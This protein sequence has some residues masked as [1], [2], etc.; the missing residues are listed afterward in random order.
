MQRLRQSRVLGAPRIEVGPYGYEHAQ[1]ASRAARGEQKVEEA[2]PL[3][4]F[5]AEGEDLLE[6]IHHHPA[7]R[8]V[9]PRR[10]QMSVGGRGPGSWCEDAKHRGTSLLRDLLPQQGNQ[11]GPQ[12]GGLAAAGRPEHHG[13]RG[14]ARQLAQLVDQPVPAEEQLTVVRLETREATVGRCGVGILLPLLPG[15]RLGLR[16]PR[17]PRGGVLPA[18]LDVGLEHGQRRQ[19]LAAR[20]LRQGRHREAGRLRHGPV[21]HATRRTAQLPKIMGESLHGTG[22]R[23]DR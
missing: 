6:L 3:G 14:P 20:R 16:P 2:V 12:Q 7:L 1:S 23:V 13:E 19:S 4:A 18:C 10:Q 5:A 22:R 8:I 11:T 9:G 17:L 15:Q 21:R